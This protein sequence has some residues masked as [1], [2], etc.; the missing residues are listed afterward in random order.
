MM[1][2]PQRQAHLS[3]SYKK[4]EE[5]STFEIPITS[6]SVHLSSRI[7]S[8]ILSQDPRTPLISG[9]IRWH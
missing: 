6:M 7:V 9:W 5:R 1:I 3:N 2:D 8:V 4:L